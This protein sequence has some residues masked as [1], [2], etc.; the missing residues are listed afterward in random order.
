MENID[1]LFAQRFHEQKPENKLDSSLWKDF[2]KQLEQEMPAAKKSNRK[3]WMGWKGLTLMNTILL[4]SILAVLLYKNDSFK[5]QVSS[6][7]LSSELQIANDK[8]QSSSVVDDKNVSGSK[9]QTSVVEPAVNIEQP[10]KVAKTNVSK[11]ETF[12]TIDQLEMPESRS[13]ESNKRNQ[14]ELIQ[15]VQPEVLISS[16]RLKS[17]IIKIPKLKTNETLKLE[18]KSNVQTKKP[19]GPQYKLKLPDWLDLNSSPKRPRKGPH[20]EKPDIIPVP[21]EG[22]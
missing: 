3:W 11:K 16:D 6:S 20:K 5:F 22:F 4:G 8:L 21:V 17:E 18:T 19:Q 15:I 12:V 13:I 7:K 9:F 14:L 10:K 1:K 2:E